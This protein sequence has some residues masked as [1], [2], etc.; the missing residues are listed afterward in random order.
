MTRMEIVALYVALNI[1][2]LIW[3]TFRVIAVRRKDLVSLGDNENTR[4]RR[5]IRAHGNFIEYAPLAL[6]GLFALAQFEVSH[7]GLHI[8]GLLFVI[9]RILHPF[10]LEGKNAVGKGRLIGMLM[11]LLALIGTALYL[12]FLIFS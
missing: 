5:R 8:I 9:G 1:L 6:I 11:T 7:I 10:G 12:L 2:I 4:L 3:L